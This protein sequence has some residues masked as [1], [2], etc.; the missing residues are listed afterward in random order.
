MLQ[1]FAV[2]PTERDIFFDDFYDGCYGT[3]IFVLS[4]TLLELPFTIV[5]AFIF[6]AATAFVI[7]LE[8]TFSMFLIAS[9]GCFCIVTCGESLGIIF[10]TLFSSYAGLPIHICSI[11][12]SIGTTIGGIVSLKVPMPL[13]AFNY[14]S[15]IKYMIASLA[16]FSMHDRKFSCSAETEAYSTISG[17]ELLTLYNLNADGQLNLIVLGGVTIAYRLIAF[18]VVKASMQEWRMRTFGLKL[19]KKEAKDQV[20]L[21]LG[22]VS[23]RANND[24]VSFV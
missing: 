15:P 17:E 14:L 6:G 1:N 3:T 8:T 12:I 7:Q 10:S 18:G 23:G 4:Y 2:Y 13:Q 20:S 21:E 24:F 5:S 9:F 16:T 11:F 22:Y 19:H